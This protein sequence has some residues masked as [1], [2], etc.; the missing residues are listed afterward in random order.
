MAAVVL[1]T[2]G[3]APA[4]A[5]EAV[6]RFRQYDQQTLE[7]QYQVKEDEEKFLATSLA[8]AQQLEKLFEADRERSEAAPRHG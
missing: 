4:E 8:A 5:R 1:Q 7:A 3:V 2:L 6:R